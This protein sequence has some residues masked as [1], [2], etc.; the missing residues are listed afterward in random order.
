MK[1]CLRFHSRCVAGDA[2]GSAEEEVD[3]I[4][5]AGGAHIH[6]MTNLSAVYFQEGVAAHLAEAETVERHTA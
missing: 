6:E 5:E 3:L 2:P 1:L 4:V